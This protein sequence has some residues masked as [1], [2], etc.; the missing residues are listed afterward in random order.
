MKLL[1]LKNIGFIYAELYKLNEKIKFVAYKKNKKIES[2]KGYG[3]LKL[4]F[5]SLKILYIYTFAK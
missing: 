1:K 5:F 2:R 3:Y 4:I